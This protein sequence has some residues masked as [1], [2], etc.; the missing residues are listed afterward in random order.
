MACVSPGDAPQALAG[1]VRRGCVRAAEED[2]GT[3]SDASFCSPGALAF[4]A[5]GRLNVIDHHRST[6]G[7][8]ALR[9]LEPV[10][11]AA[12]ENIAVRVRSRVRGDYGPHM[13]SNRNGHIYLTSRSRP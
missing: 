8:T 10:S 11:G 13:I 5:Q 2:D 12:A 6:S 3:G 7:Q 4:D 9:V 1:V